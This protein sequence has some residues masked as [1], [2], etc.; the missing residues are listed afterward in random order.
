MNQIMKHSIHCIANIVDPDQ[1]ASSEAGL[2]G[3]TLFARKPEY[4]FR[5]LKTLNWFCLSIKGV[6]VICNVLTFSVKTQVDQ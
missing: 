3:S 1:P 5:K 2:S 6:Y 4:R